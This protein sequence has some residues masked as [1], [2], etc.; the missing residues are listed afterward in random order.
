[1]EDIFAKFNAMDELDVVAFVKETTELIWDKK[2]VGAIYECY[3][4]ETVI[5]GADGRKVVGADQIVADTMAWL[6]AF[7]DLKLIIRDVIWGGNPE[8]GYRSS[9]PWSYVGTNTGPSRYGPP[10][11]KQLT[12][13]NNL[14]I[15]N[16]LIQKVDGKW[17][18][19]DEYSTYDMVAS[20]RACTL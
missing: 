7:P 9:M 18:Y 14:G 13:E 4:A 3:T 6:T 11:G 8:E 19:V 16:C 15:A 17:T 2:M 1:M 20:E 12:M 10:T 5:N